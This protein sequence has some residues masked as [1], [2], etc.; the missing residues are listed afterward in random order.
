MVSSSRAVGETGPAQASSDVPASSSPLTHATHEDSSP[1]AAAMEPVSTSDAKTAHEKTELEDEASSPPCFSAREHFYAEVASMSRDRYPARLS[2]DAVP[3]P[4]SSFTICCNHCDAAIPNAHWHC[5][6]C[7]EGDFDLCTDCVSKGVLCDS[8]D[9]W[10]IKRFVKNGKVTNSTT[11]RIEPKKAR[12]PEKVMAK[13]VLGAHT[14][15][16]E[17]EDQDR[18]RVETRTCNSCIAGKTENLQLSMPLSPRSISR[19]KLLY[20]HRL[21]RL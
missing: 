14:P 15:D 12:A 21:R 19:E 4:G 20:L 9:H 5:S 17:A 18:P 7:D 2:T 6:S 8:E 16:P 1:E 3:V 11:E 13:E 10:L